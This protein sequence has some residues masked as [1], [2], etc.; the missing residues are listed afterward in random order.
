MDIADAF[1][2]VID[3]AKQNMAPT[4]MSE[5]RARQQEAINM[6]EDIAVNEYGDE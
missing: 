4:D 6:I 1:Q 2:I 3:L 5:E